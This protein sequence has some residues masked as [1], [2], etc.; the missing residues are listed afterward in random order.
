M[1]AHSADNRL[2]KAIGGGAAVCALAFMTAGMAASP[3]EWPA[4]IQSVEAHGAVG[5]TV[6]DPSGIAL[7]K[8]A[9]IGTDTQGRTRSVAVALNDGGVIRVAAFQA[10]VDPPNRMVELEL[11]A[12]VIAMRARQAEPQSAEAPEEITSPLS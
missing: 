6:V 9:E 1:D 4:R 5:Y 2:P 10:Y 8:V 3:P 7:G 12:D 11:P